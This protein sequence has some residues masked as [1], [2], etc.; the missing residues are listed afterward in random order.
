MEVRLIEYGRRVDVKVVRR[1]VVETEIILVAMERNPAPGQPPEGYIC[2]YDVESEHGQRAVKAKPN[3][4][5]VLVFTQR[6]D[7]GHSIINTDNLVGA[8]KRLSGDRWRPALHDYWE[9]F[10][11]GAPELKEAP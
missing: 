4:H 2:V 6:P 1:E 9:Y 5:G 3:D 10:A 8:L 7:S 11:A